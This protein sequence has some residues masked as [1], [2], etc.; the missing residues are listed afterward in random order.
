METVRKWFGGGDIEALTGKS[1]PALDKEFE[2]DLE[3]M[4]LPGE[5]ES[6]ARAKFSR[7]GIFGRKCPHV[8]DAL[9]HE[10]DVCRDSQRYAKAVELYREVLAKDPNDFGSRR[11][12]AN[13]ERRHLDREKGRAALEEMAKADEKKVP[14]TW[15]DRAEEALAD[16][17]LIDGSY[18]SAGARYDTLATRTVDEDAART[19]EVKALGA[20]DPSARPAVQALLLGDQKHGS[21][22]FLG[23][24]ALGVW[25][26]QTPNALV[27]Y[28]IGRN[29]VGR[30]F[31]EEGVRH[32]EEAL[33]GKLPTPRV[34]RETIRQRAIAA[35]ALGDLDA[36]GR[37]R[38]WI[39]GPE[40]PFKGASG[41]RREST[42]RMIARCSA[43]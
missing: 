37:M 36:L 15:R 11:D 23:G 42:L 32:L 4:G 27:S 3:K 16:A 17:E 33:A 14:R 43:K 1:W 13:V 41:G 28:L 35:C 31:Y 22:I 24:V 9:R 12:A 30:G 40:D 5:A 19:F 25:K 34:A 39:E 38:S 6:F 10:A 21:D 29:L 20:R 18:E 2:T 8:V 26:T 7:P